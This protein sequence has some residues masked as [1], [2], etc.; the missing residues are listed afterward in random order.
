[1]VQ[2]T[3]RLSDG[4]PII[5][6][7]VVESIVSQPESDSAY[8]N[9]ALPVRPYRALIDTGATISCVCKHVVK[10]MNLRPYGRIPMI[11]STGQSFHKTYIVTLGLMYGWEG[12][13]D[14]APNPTS[15]YQIDPGEVA[16]IENN[17][18]FDLIIGTD[19]LTRFTFTLRKGGAFSLDLS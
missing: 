9:L 2:A 12:Q 10:S 19:I 16:E 5:D 17:A 6:V 7:V 1:M 18:W 15:F 11:G 14:Y 8:T 13:A 4:K 3:G